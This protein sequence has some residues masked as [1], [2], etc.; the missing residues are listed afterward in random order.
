MENINQNL[1]NSELRFLVFPGSYMG[2]GQFFSSESEDRFTEY[3]R[4][5]DEGKISIEDL[6]TIRDISETL[7]LDDFDDPKIKGLEKFLTDLFIAKN[8][9]SLTVPFRNYG[10]E[11]EDFEKL[12]SSPETLSEKIAPV[13]LFEKNGE[14]FAG[15][16]KYVKAAL[17]LRDRL[18][19]RIRENEKNYNIAEEKI[20]VYRDAVSKTKNMLNGV[21]ANEQL[22][23]VAVSLLNTSFSL[24]T[25]GPGTGKTTV[26]FSVI[27]SLM[28]AGEIAP[29]DIC[30]LAPTG[31]ASVRI[32]EAVAY[33]GKKAGITELENIESRTV[34]RF[35]GQIDLRERPVKRNYKLVVVDE[36]SMADIYLM[37][38]LFESIAVRGEDYPVRLILVGD[39]NQLP[40]VEAGTVM[41]DLS[42]GKLNPGP[43]EKYV[44]E[45]LGDDIFENSKDPSSIPEAFRHKLNI[46]HRSDNDSLKNAFMCVREMGDGRQIKAESFLQKY[47]PKKNSLSEKGAFIYPDC[48]DMKKSIE[49]VSRYLRTAC[50]EKDDSLG[51]S[52]TDFVRELSEK[53]DFS[54][55]CV[56]EKNIDDMKK[57]FA[58]P[59]K[60]RVLCP[61]RGGLL[62]CNAINR[63][64][65][66]EYSQKVS[67]NYKGF[68]NGMS[69][70]ITRNDYVYNVFNG[71]VGIVLR[72][73]KGVYKLVFENNG[74]YAGYSPT[75]F[76]YFEDAFAI[77][78]HKSQGSE[79]GNVLIP[80]PEFGDDEDF[81]TNQLIYTAIT[82]AKNNFIFL[83]SYDTFCK[84]CRNV[85]VRENAIDMF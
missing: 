8:T 71:D 51:M 65:L 59:G 67:E 45:M 23:A 22:T 29:E 19:E 79:Y 35:L 61:K 58:H 37:A 15:F 83:G 2:E 42:L 12:F 74:N 25:G 38:A 56:F 76:E 52:Y 20:S 28:N 13:V 53:L 3:S 66:A 10:F 44:R 85:S 47:D 46:N 69:I 32:K 81:L 49:F 60:Y 64:F 9:G 4:L 75:G 73:R 21:I 31:K 33:Q 26:V 43:M 18:A 78:I 40:S 82:R 48:T 62:G 77:T 54:D 7:G 63:R 80:C 11:K 27:A 41:A 16:H 39:F 1:G 30:V 6:L 34:H 36:V 68:R 5:Y 57:L 50:F 70:M 84:M 55:D 72:D 17:V 14:M 24:I